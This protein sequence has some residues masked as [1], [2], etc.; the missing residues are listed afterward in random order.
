MLGV[1]P[2]IGTS[3]LRLWIAAGAAALLLMVYGLAFVRPLASPALRASFVVFGAILGAAMT[4]ALLAPSAGGD[5]DAERRALE[6]RAQELGALAL[7]PGSPLAC[8]DPLAG[9][10]V[11]AGCE[12]ALFVSP[13]SV[14]SASSYVGARLR[15]LAD[16]A[17]YA[18]RGGT[19]IESALVPLRHSLEADRFGFVAHVLAV[20]D[21]CI[22]QDCKALTLFRDASHVRTNLSARIFDQYLSRYQEAW[23]K[24]PETVPAEATQAMPSPQSA[25]RKVVNID[26]PSAASIPP[27]SIMN[28]EPSG[29]ILPGVAAAA[30]ASRN[31][32]TGAAP[33]PR[34][35]RKQAAG[36]AAPTAAQAGPAA[37][38]PIW[39][40][41]LPPAPP[42]PQTAAAPA[43]AAMQLSSPS[44]NASVGAGARTP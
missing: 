37:V 13:A 25:P 32:P 8:L 16:M 15:L 1:D 41:P 7:V 35:P 11:E 40:E 2:A 18:E 36:V 14:A 3:A 20:R 29:P 30:A 38:D 17:A 10:A 19:G 42:P 43:G 34:R 22:S 6:V 28:P 39:P 27:V 12:K 31:P 9:D 44:P 26:F 24:T 21:G 23:T 4:W 33:A 5:R